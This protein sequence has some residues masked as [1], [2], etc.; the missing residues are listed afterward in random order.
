MR[1]KQNDPREEG[2]RVA[3]ATTAYDVAEQE[4]AE[5]HWKRIRAIMSKVP[6]K[7]MKQ[8]PRDG[9]EQHDHYIYGTP[10]RPA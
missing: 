4:L 8:L 2:T 9:A 3:E 6:R 7:Q 5:P 1:R 10:K